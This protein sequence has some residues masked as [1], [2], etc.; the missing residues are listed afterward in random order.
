[1][2]GQVSYVIGFLSLQV[3]QSRDLV[4]NHGLFSLQICPELLVVKLFP[5][6]MAYELYLGERVSRRGPYEFAAVHS[7]RT[8]LYL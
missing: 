5:Y 3:P 1:M 2:R 8:K 4:L 6:R 7:R